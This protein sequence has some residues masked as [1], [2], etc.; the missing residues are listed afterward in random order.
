MPWSPGELAG[1]PVGHEVECCPAAALALAR[2]RLET[3]DSRVSTFVSPGIFGAHVV[4]WT[5]LLVQAA[6][7]P[8]RAAALHSCT[9]SDR[10]CPPPA[11]P[12]PQVALANGAEA[13]DLAQ[14]LPQRWQQFLR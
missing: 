1:L 5:R 6:P 10:P 3:T 7:S 8:R 9:Q 2:P 11:R 13:L 14:L 4:H 12:W